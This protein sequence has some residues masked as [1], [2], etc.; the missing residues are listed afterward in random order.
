M[1][2]LTNIWTARILVIVGFLAGWNSLGSTFAH[3][4]NDAFL[5]TDQAPIVQTH[6]WHH[7]LRELGAQFGAMAAILVILFA[8]PRYRTPIT[9]WVVLILMIGFYAPFWIG[10]P[11]DP[12]YGA[13]NMSAEIN[14]LSM[15]VPAL[16]GAFL[17]KRHFVGTD[18]TVERSPVEVRG[19]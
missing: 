6:S 12:A 11:F 10:V 8:A 9:W 5:L 1:K 2:L 17:A 15:A 13:P 19:A 18:R 7:F 14:H 16:L 4:G 3:I